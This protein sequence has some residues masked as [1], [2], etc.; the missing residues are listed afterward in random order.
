MRTGEARE[1]SGETDSTEPE[2]RVRQGVGTS[3]AVSLGTKEQG[4]IP[5]R[6][7]CEEGDQVCALGGG[8]GYRDPNSPH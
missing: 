8:H 3:W 6:T 7:R 5:A 1:R 2:A 4:S